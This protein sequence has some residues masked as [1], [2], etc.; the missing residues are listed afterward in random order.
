MSDSLRLSTKQISTFLENQ[1]AEIDARAEENAV[2]REEIAANAAIAE[3]SVAAQLEVQ[4]LQQTHSLTVHNNRKGIIYT[5]LTFLFIFA[6]VALYL[7]KETIV[8]ELVKLAAA[9][10][11]GGGVGYYYGIKNSHT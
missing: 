3:K 10:A 4:K 9:F 8:I 5:S 1:R 11:G 6:V 7:D 2:R